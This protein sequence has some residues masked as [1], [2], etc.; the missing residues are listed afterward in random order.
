VD[1]CLP[2]IPALVV[3]YHAC[4]GFLVKDTWLE[5]I[6]AGNCDTFAGLFYSNVAHY[7]PDSDETVLR[8]LAQMLQ[9]VRS[10]KPQLTSHPNL[11]L[12]IKTPTPLAEASQEVFLCVYPVSKLHADG[13]GCFPVRALSGNQYVMIAY[14]MDGNLILQQAF[15]MNAI[16]HCI[17]AFNTIMERLAACG[18]LVDLNISDNEASADFK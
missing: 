12:I 9:S 18:L 10:T 11:P 14:H 15:Q 5:G 7:C 4:L 3:F 6:K 13:M 2:S 17:P 8:H 16:K 1:T